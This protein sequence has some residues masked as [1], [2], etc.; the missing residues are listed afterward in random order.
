MGW[1]SLTHFANHLPNTV[2]LPIDLLAQARSGGQF[3]QD[4]LGDIGKGWNN[5]V[6]SG[7]LI[8]V[9]I[10]LVL[11]YLLRTVTGG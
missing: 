11:G 2:H 9:I 10:G 6:Q 4:V 1:D 7:Q 5:F 3:N 8:A